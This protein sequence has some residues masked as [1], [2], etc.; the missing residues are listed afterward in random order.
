MIALVVLSTQVCVERCFT[1]LRFILSHLRTRM[2]DHILEDITGLYKPID[3]YMQT[4][5]SM[6]ADL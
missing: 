1:G 5:R 6:Y 2:T 4:Y 3:P